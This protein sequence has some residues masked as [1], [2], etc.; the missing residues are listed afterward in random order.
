MSEHIVRNKLKAV[1]Q[2][3]LR[4]TWLLFEGSKNKSG[5]I[6]LSNHC[7]AYLQLTFI[8]TPLVDPFVGIFSHSSSE[9]TTSTGGLKLELLY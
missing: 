5:L 4:E 6:I 2:L 3:C 7:I 9:V 1:R 8:V